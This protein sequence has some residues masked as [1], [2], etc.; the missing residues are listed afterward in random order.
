VTFGRSKVRNE[1]SQASLVASTGGYVAVL[2]VTC[3]ATLVAA[4]TALGENRP[5]EDKAHSTITLAIVAAVIV[6]AIAAAALPHTRSASS[7]WVLLPAL[8]ACG[9]FAVTVVLLAYDGTAEAVDY[10]KHPLRA[11]TLELS[12]GAW[13]R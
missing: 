8:L 3:G 9:A 6:V 2:V 4:A 10:W 13:R 5:S 1:R 12:S 11:A 7:Y